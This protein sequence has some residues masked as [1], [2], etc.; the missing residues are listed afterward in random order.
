MATLLSDAIYGSLLALRAAEASRL[1]MMPYQVLSDNIIRE[2]LK[3]QPKS[4]DSLKSTSLLASLADSSLAE[5]IVQ[6][7]ASPDLQAPPLASETTSKDENIA[8]TSTI[9]SF[10]RKRGPGA[11]LAFEEDDEPKTPPANLDAPSLDSRDLKLYEGY[12]KDMKSVEIIQSDTNEGAENVQRRLLNIFASGYPVQLSRLGITSEKVVY[13]ALPT[14]LA[15]RQGG[16]S[17]GGGLRLEKEDLTS[18]SLSSSIRLLYP[19]V[20]PLAIQLALC[21]WYHDLHPELQLNSALYVA[22]RSRSKRKEPSETPPIDIST[23]KSTSTITVAKKNEFITK[24][25][26]TSTQPIRK[27][28]RLTQ[29]AKLLVS[30]FNRDYRE[31]IGL[32]EDEPDIDSDPSADYS[33]KGEDVA[34]PSDIWRSQGFRPKKM[35]KRSGAPTSIDN[36]GFVS[37]QGNMLK[38]RVSLTDDDFSGTE[39]A[40]FADVYSPAKPNI[41]KAAVVHMQS[42]S[43]LTTKKAEKE[44]ESVVE[45]TEAVVIP[46]LQNTNSGVQKPLSTASSSVSESK[47]VVNSESSSKNSVSSVHYEGMS[48]QDIFERF[49]RIRLA[50]AIGP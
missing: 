29:Q 40:Y 39:E 49:N 15:L 26:T 3:H 8:K 17:G 30:G 27:S 20:S 50:A 18:G 41:P 14:V 4:I 2:L 34:R 19:D 1:G 23:P 10:T 48:A 7:F 28:P 31:A 42:N 5:S 43:V 33:N 11:I 44:E 13:N 38:E 35:A 46:K 12:Q 22:P 47:S 32:A 21:E 45:A 37:F 24:S 25:S 9:P 16:S 6:L 36:V